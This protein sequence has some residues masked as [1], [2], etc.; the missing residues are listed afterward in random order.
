MPL[1]GRNDQAV[2]ANTITTVESSNGAPIGTAALVKGGKAQN[3]SHATNSHFGNT[4]AG[5]MA[6]VD[7]TMFGNVTTSAFITGMQVGVFGVSAS[8]QSNNTVNKVADQPQHAGWNLRKAGTGSIVSITYTGTA[9]AYANGDRVIVTSPVAGGNA[10]FVL[11]TNT[12][13]GNLTFT[14]AQGGFGFFNTNATTNAVYANSGNG[15]TV[16]GSGATFNPVAGG[17]AG[18]IHYETLVASGSLGAQT[19]PYGTPALVADATGDNTKF[20]G[21]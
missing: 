3:I 18:R 13:G 21:T 16:T 11:A 7:A 6:S 10:Y 4:S 19:A 5:S 15:A 12:S 17:R 14:L 1:W 20:P 2:T 8:E 9:T